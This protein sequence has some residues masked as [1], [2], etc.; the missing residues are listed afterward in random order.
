MLGFLKRLTSQAES[1]DATQDIKPW[2]KSK[3]INP[4]SVRHFVYDDPDLY[5]NY[6]CN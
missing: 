6:I 5:P 2:F 4:S 1:Y 3:G